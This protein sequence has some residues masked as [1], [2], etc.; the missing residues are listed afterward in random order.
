MIKTCQEE[1]VP[2]QMTQDVLAYLR[3]TLD[4]SVPEVPNDPEPEEVSSPAQSLDDLTSIDEDIDFETFLADEP[5]SF[6]AHMQAFLHDWQGSPAIKRLW[7]RVDMNGTGVYLVATWKLVS[8][9]G[10]IWNINGMPEIIGQKSTVISS[11]GDD[12]RVHEDGRALCASL[13]VELQHTIKNSQS[14]N[15]GRTMTFRGTV[16]VWALHY[17]PNR[18]FR[19]WLNEKVP[20]GPQRDIRQ[21]LNLT[22]PSSV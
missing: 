12:V 16:F 11:S 9:D 8:E 5:P 2:Q 19:F 15:N 1:Q 7:R 4:L 22:M 6:K 20:N 21:W 10:T 17:V 3:D 14:A 18:K 13:D